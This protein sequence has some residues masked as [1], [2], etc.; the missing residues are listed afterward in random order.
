MCQNYKS[1]LIMKLVDVPKLPELV[2]LGDVPKLQR[3]LDLSIS[4]MKVVEKVQN[5]LPLH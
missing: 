5:L 4:V 1:E 2:I 3:Y